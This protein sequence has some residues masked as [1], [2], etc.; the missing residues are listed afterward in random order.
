MRQQ[1]GEKLKRTGSTP[2]SKIK[3]F[4]LV[5]PNGK[6]HVWVKTK[7]SA[8]SSYLAT[9]G[10]IV[11][12]DGDWDIECERLERDGWKIRSATLVVIYDDEC[13]SK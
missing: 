11:L 10:G 4:V 5:K 1:V 7:R 6:A 3:G 8:I 12:D 2:V 9:K 13:D